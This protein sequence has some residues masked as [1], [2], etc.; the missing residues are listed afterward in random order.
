M[1][2]KH[3]SPQ[4][5]KSLNCDSI[6]KWCDLCILK[7]FNWLE[8]RTSAMSVFE[9]FSNKE[10]LDLIEGQQKAIKQE[11]EMHVKYWWMSEAIKEKT[12]KQYSLFFFFEN[13][14]Y[15]IGELKFWISERDRS[16]RTVVSPPMMSRNSE[17]QS[18][19]VWVNREAIRNI[20]WYT[21]N[22]IPAW[23][24]LKRPVYVEWQHRLL[25]DEHDLVIVNWSR[26]MWKSFTISQK[27]IEC[28]FLP[29]NDTLVWAFLVST[30]NVIRNY[31]RKL[32]RKFPEGMFEYKAWERYLINLETWTKIYF[33]T[34]GDDAQNILGL[35]LKRVIVDE[36]Q[37]I[38]Q[39]VF[40]EVLE[41]TLSTTGWQMIMIWTP[42]RKRSGY[43]FDK[44]TQYKKWMLP[45][46]SFYEVDVTKNPFIAPKKRAYI[47]ANKHEYAIRR[48]WFCEWSD[49]SDGLFPFRK[50]HKLPDSM[51]F[52]YLVLW[53]D[54]ARI[55]DRSSYC[56]N[57]VYE[58]KIYWSFSWFVPDAFKKDWQLQAKFYI[59]MISAFKDNPNFYI[60]MDITW[61]WDWVLK[62]FRNEGLKIDFTARYTWS[63]GDPNIKDATEFKVWKSYLINTAVDFMQ[64]WTYEI[65][66]PTNSDLMEEISYAVEDRN[67]KW[68]IQMDTTF[69][70]DTIN[71][72]MISLLYI[73][74]RNLV[75]RSMENTP[76]FE[77]SWVRHI[78]V[79]DGMQ[80]WEEEVSHVW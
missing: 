55:N 68:M 71:A 42:G 64:E 75:S 10:I 24:E 32:I 44:I 45:D 49:W 36:A 50:C 65:Y 9:S 40:E 67:S 59:N 27:L 6:C 33:R 76:S 73:K 30:T 58:W 8:Y 57:H 79:F 72:M 21:Y 17:M 31:C 28:S 20:T 14:F 69:Y 47:M 16:E 51:E 54:P 4:K 48:Q 66:A 34:L 7:K 5:H 38:S 11:C 74:Q 25:E 52:W 46:A 18:N 56:L 63:W 43:M 29:N 3:Y 53:L 13:H 35:T 37:L 77:T 2:I 62:I 26:Q 19:I 22:P 80:Y 61:V 39:F 41:P 60:W 1:I 78:D 15:N 23:D 70:D 12:L